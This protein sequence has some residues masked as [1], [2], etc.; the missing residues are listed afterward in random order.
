MEINELVI[1]NITESKLAA[2]IKTAVAEALQN[3]NTINEKDTGIWLSRIEA[4]KHLKIA[5]PT[6]DM[7]AKKGKIHPVRLGRQVRYNLEELNH[8]ISSQKIIITL[9]K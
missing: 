3:T 6:L 4:S 8:S 2:L 1:L 7:L 9:K 5:L